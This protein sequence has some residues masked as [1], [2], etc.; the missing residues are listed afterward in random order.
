LNELRRAGEI[1]F[2]APTM[3]YS[4]WASLPAVFYH[5]AGR[6]AERNFL[7]AKGEG[8]YRPMTWRETERTVTDLA[9]G[10]RALGLARGERVVL[11]SENRPEWL[12]ADVA[13]MTAGGITVPAYTTS[14]TSD[15]RHILTDSGACGVIVS[16]QALARRILSAA[17]D[18]P[19]CK[20]VIV[21]E[22]MSLGQSVT[23][24][25]HHWTAV[26]A[27]G[28]AVDDDDAAAMV[29][30]I[31]RGDTACFIYTS[32]TG[33]APKGVMLSHGAILCNCMGAHA[34]LERLG[35]ER[36]VFLSF[37]P[38]SHAYEHTAGQFFPMSIGAE[39]YYCTG[40]EQLL[41]N[42]AEARP[43]IMTAVPRLY[44]SM[45]QR[46]LRG[47]EKQ[48]GL[49]KR[50]FDL[51]LR[52][53]RKR[54]HAPHGLSPVERLLDL[55]V[56]RLVR[57][58]IRARFGGRLKAMVSGGAA[59]NPDIGIF[60]TALG[61]PVLQ[62][63]G[64]S[65]AAPVISANPPGRVKMETVGPPLKGVEARIAADGEILVR[66]ELVMRGY[67]QNEDATAAVLR[68]GWLHTG[69][70][71]EIDADGYLKIT[72]RKKDI[73][74]LSGGDNVS[75]A[76]IE[77]FLTLQPEI[78]QAMVYGD[79]R[80]HL[81]ALLVPDETFLLEFAG[82]RGA[83]PDLARLREDAEF[84]AAMS[85]VVDRVNAELATLEKVRRFAIAAEQFTVENEMMTPTL[86]IRRHRIVETYGETLQDL[87]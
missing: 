81:V 59:L 84:K 68:D 41:T 11:L 7:W 48:G 10:L 1:G 18:A 79:K 66:G 40:V 46:I 36:E 65:E 13:I 60:F 71:G 53:G 63:Y 64:Q 51:A 87:Y 21:I 74:V 27:M 72:D 32:G 31:K 15:H 45:Y 20:W 2:G 29:G 9:R 33:G 75:P 19:D 73:L 78:H 4:T 67:W 76:R 28:A 17:M 34:L 83:A 3:D 56:D 80:P 44:E 49:K 52:L 61:L 57:D 35:L 58:K 30:E 25:L 43:T 54:Y 82:A 22:D 69:D 16:T 70:I 24:D 26:L 77:G 86:K 5:H 62:G 39:I 8:A 47:V 42:L 23:I 6:L 12:I 14:T 85:A 55:V 50:L 38:L 37:L